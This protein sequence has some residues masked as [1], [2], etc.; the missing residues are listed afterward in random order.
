MWQTI[1]L[2]IAVFL[3]VF[4]IIATVVD[5][6]KAIVVNRS[7]NFFPQIIMITIGLSYIIWY[8]N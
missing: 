7:Y 1:F 2:V 8:C 6:T 3:V 5:L 4:G